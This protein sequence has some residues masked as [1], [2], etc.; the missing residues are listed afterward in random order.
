[1]ATAA[2]LSRPVSCG[3][4]T[5]KSRQLI[6]KHSVSCSAS[7]QPSG[8]WKRDY[9]SVM[10]VPTGV[11][12]SI[13]GYAGDA[14]PVARALSSVVDCLISHPNVK[15]FPFAFCNCF[16]E[17]VLSCGVFY[18]YEGDEWTFLAYFIHS[19]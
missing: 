16:S 18:M 17:L 4:I 14:L 6:P 5:A 15:L 11:G 12:A 7:Y 10:I 13:G 3:F 19:I 9:T 1:M 2:H 8:K